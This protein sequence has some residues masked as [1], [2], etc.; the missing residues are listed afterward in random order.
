MANDRDIKAKAA[1]LRKTLE[2]LEK[3]SGGSKPTS[4]VVSKQADVAAFTRRSL[5]TIKNWAKQGM[6]GKAGAYDLAEIVQWAITK[7]PWKI[8]GKQEGDDPL[9]AGAS[10]SPGL[11]RYRLAKA[12][13]AEYDL[14]ERKGELIARDKV[15]GSFSRLAMM[16]RRTGER[17]AKNYGSGA[18]V[19]WND[20]I[21]EFKRSVDDDFGSTGQ[22]ADNSAAD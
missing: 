7:G 11:E 2:A 9:L 4:F 19:L 13:I 12:E 18:A 17:L 8:D 21:T 14:Q 6:P 22:P 5:D 1:Q 16:A 15:R 3:I 20:F 10:D